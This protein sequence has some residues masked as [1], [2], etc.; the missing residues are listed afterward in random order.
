MAVVAVVVIVVV[1][2]GDVVAAVAEVITLPFFSQDSIRKLVKEAENI[3]KIRVST[4][5]LKEVL[6]ANSS[7]QAD[8]I[9][10]KIA[11]NE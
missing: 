3:S 6:H 1:I 5:L 8:L 4:S 11:G 10:R 7:E 9:I 2:V